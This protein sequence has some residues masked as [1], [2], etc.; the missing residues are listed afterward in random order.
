MGNKRKI[1]Q[2]IANAVP[3]P[4]AEAVGRAILARHRGET[5]PAVEEGFTDWLCRQGKGV[6]AAR[7]VKANINRARKL[8]GGRTYADRALEIGRLE[9]AE[10]F[11][12][13]PTQT[14]SDLRAALRLYADYQDDGSARPLA[15]A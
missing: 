8:L 6:S 9:E 4:L 3:P 15:A 1:D 2:A 11:G 7:N 10:G 12:G 13:L 5:I 14:K